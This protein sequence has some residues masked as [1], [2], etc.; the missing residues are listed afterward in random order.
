MGDKANCLT[1]GSLPTAQG[2]FRQ[3]TAAPKGDTPPDDMPAK[4]F[5]SEPTVLLTPR[6]CAWLDLSHKD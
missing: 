1:P 4:R 6:S 5:Y 2:E 3:S